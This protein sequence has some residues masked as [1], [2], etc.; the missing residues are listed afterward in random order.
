LGSDNFSVFPYDRVCGGCEY[1]FRFMGRVGDTAYNRGS[2]VR[3]MEQDTT[4]LVAVAR[5]DAPAD[6][7]FAGGRILNVFSGEIYRAD[8]AVAGGYIASVGPP[9]DAVEIIDTSGLT[10]LPGLIDAHVHMESSLLAPAAFSRALVARGTTSV[11]CDPHEIANVAGIEGIRWILDAGASTALKILIN[12]PS[13][14]P[15]SGLATSGAVLE[16]ADL[17]G[18]IDH[19]RVLGLGEM[20]NY[21]GVIAG[22]PGVFS[23]IAAFSG[24]MVDGHA[25]GLRGEQLQ[26]YIAAGIRSDHECVDPDEALEK[27]R[28][29][30]FILLRQGTAAHNLL[31]LLPMLTKDN[32]SR[33]ALCTDD[34]HPGDLVEEGH[35]DHLLRM[36]IN[37]GL[38]PV[39]AVRLATINPARIYGL[40]DRGAIAPGRVADLVFCKDLRDLRAATVVCGGRICAREGVPVDVEPEPGGMPALGA[41]RVDEGSLDF[42]I[43]DRGSAVKVIDLQEGQLTSAILVRRMPVV[44]GYL[45]ADL[46]TA[47][48]KMAV[49]ER[50]RGSGRI[51]LGFIRGLG[52]RAGAIA[53]SVAHD[54]HNL[55]VAGMD[56]ESMLTAARA[57]TTTQGG[58]VAA[59]GTE[60]LARLPLPIAGLMTRASLPEVH[61]AMQALLAATR[62]LGSPLRDPFMLLSFAAL[63]VIPALRLTDQGLV[64]VESFRLVPLEA[65]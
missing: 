25:P 49:I 29:G 14:V 65:D 48:A 44:A 32:L 42:G 11:V 56:D 58:L 5:G 2:G 64:D 63:E 36:I 52:L 8:V 62:E 41:F 38:D 46:K 60:V 10:L 16:A 17:L 43:R 6:L 24:R 21:P 39:D 34:R 61:T 47:V 18:L 3:K 23:K 37:E 7:L 50:H 9:R 13:C 31:D 35:L 27:L 59:R 26:A 55:V 33:C 53:S 40:H 1:P 51:G 12:L 54:H 20:M 4:R 57:V 22:D 19:P 15:A 30:M 45:G 28:L